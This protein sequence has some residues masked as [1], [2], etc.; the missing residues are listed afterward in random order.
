MSAQDFGFDT[1]VPH[2][3]PTVI[4]QASYWTK[5]VV[6][7]SEK[8]NPDSDASS[9]RKVGESENASLQVHMPLAGCGLDH[10]FA[11]FGPVGWS[12]DA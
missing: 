11:R 12:R 1:L 3:V 5:V 10:G 6:T 4:Q 7:P 2:S 9:A 8:S